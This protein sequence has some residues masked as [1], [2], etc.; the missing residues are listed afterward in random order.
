MLGFIVNC[1]SSS[2]KVR[3]I[4]TFTKESLFEAK[5][6]HL[7]TYSSKITS[8]IDCF[9][10]DL[11]PE[12]ACQISH[13]GA[14]DLILRNLESRKIISDLK[15]ISFVGHRIVHGGTFFSKPTVITEEVIEKITLCN[16]L[17]PL[18]NPVGILGIRCCQKLFPNAI[19]IAVFDTAFHQTIPEINFKYAIPNRFYK[20]GIRKYGFHGTS[21]SYSTRV[22][23]DTIKDEE[24][25]SSIIAHIGQGTS[26][27]AIKKGKSV[28][29][30]MEFSPLSG[31]VMGTRSGT[32][33][34]A[35][36]Q[37]MCN[38]FN[39]S[40][41][42]VMNILNKESGLRSLADTCNMIEIL[43]GVEEK[44]PTCIFA[45]VYFCNSIAE[46]I[47]KAIISLGE[48]PKQI[49]FTGG[50][51][52]NSYLVRELILKKISCIVDEFSLNYQKNLKNNFLITDSTSKLSVYVIKANEEL[53]IA[54]E[55]ANLIS[56]H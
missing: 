25:L 29:T 49:V 47:A 13:D 4:D 10:C 26:V 28:Y 9:S 32:I 3:L 53:E 30:S 42:Q 34:P 41:D 2:I 40:L 55:A 8:K 50:I 5:A 43:N 14:L 56:Q 46:N 24:D 27:C 12:D 11:T 45:L 20:N 51:G 7:G 35:I 18:H 39:Y 52:E 23:L 17:A 48:K 6:E 36:I 44:D 38:S 22:L 21:Y 37:Y 19:Q 15:D 33:D 1:G 54:L 16:N 31:C